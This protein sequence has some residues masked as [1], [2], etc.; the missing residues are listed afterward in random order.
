ME[1]FRPLR[2]A[3]C[4]YETARLA[5]L[6]GVF[7]VLQPEGALAFPWLALITPGALFAL[8]A[9]FWRLN[10][11]RYRLYCP[12]YLAGKGF[13]VLTTFFWIFFIK[14]D[15]MRG[16]LFSGTA[17]LVMPGIA[18]FLLLGDI[19]SAWIAAKLMTIR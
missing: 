5:F 8:M 2:T 10:L 9:L 16:L 12:L 7:L 18:V 3:L 1:E 15:T 17:L 11:P 13:S 14:S 4:I 19:L 6:I